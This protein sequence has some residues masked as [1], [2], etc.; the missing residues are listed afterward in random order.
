MIISFLIKYQKTIVLS[1]VAI[2]AYTVAVKASTI[3]TNLHYAALVLVENAQLA[4]NAALAVGRGFVVGFRVAVVALTRGVASARVA[5]QMLTKS[6]AA[7]PWGAL[8]VAVA[9]ATA[10]LVGFLSQTKRGEE[11][12]KRLASQLAKTNGEI[13]SER[14]EIDKLFHKLR[15]AEEGTSQYRKAKDEILSKY[16]QY[17][18]GLGQEVEALNDVAE[19]YRIITME[20]TNAARARGLAEA[21]KTADDTFNDTL[22]EQGRSLYSGLTGASRKVRVGNGSRTE[23]LSRNEVARWMHTLIA[24]ATQRQFTSG[25][26]DFLR[27][28]GV[29]MDRN[30]SWQG[31]DEVADALNKISEASFDRSEEVFT[32]SLIFGTP[33]NTYKDMTALQVER[34]MIELRETL[35]QN[36]S[37]SR[38]G[39]SAVLPN[40]NY[41]RFENN[42]DIQNELSQLEVLLERLQNADEG[43]VVV[44]SAP[45]DPNAPQGFTLP[46]SDKDRRKR[47]LEE[48]RRQIKERQD[49]KAALNAEKGLWEQEDT[50][51]TANYAAG[52]IS[53]REYLEQRQAILM[54]YFEAREDVY[55][56]FGLASEGEEDEDFL[57]LQKRKTEALLAWQRRQSQLSIDEIKREQQAVEAEAQLDFVTP[58][59]RLYRNEEALQQRLF[60]IRADYLDRILQ[61]Q[62]LTA[63]ERMRYE[64]QL[65]DLEGKEML[66]R[67]QVLAKRVQE[68]T[69]RYEYLSAQERYDREVEMLDAALEQNLINYKQYFEILKDLQKKYKDEILPDMAKPKSGKKAKA[70]AD[71]KEHDEALTRVEQLYQKGELSKEEYEAAKDRIEDEYF[72]RSE[73]RA[74][75]VGSTYTNQL[76][77]VYDAFKS[78]FDKSGEDGEHWA[79]KLG[80]LV[81]AVSGIMIGMMEQVTEYQRVCSEIELARV[82]KKYDREIELAEGNSYRV[83]QAE[84]AKERETARIKRESQRKMFAVQVASAVAQTAT[85]ALQAFGSA[86]WLPY[87]AS[88]I[89]GALAAAM[90]TAAGVVQIAT[91]KK[92]QQ[93]A[94]VQGYS[95]GGFTP[96]GK[97]DEAVGVVHAGEWVASQRLVNSPQARPLIEALDYAQRTNTIGSLR[98]ADVS[99]SITAPIALA[100][101]GQTAP[102]QQIVVQSAPAVVM[103]DAEL[104]KVISRLDSRLNEPFVTVATVSGDVGINRAQDEYSKLMRNKTPKSRRK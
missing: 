26:K 57:E 1:T 23:A 95:Q 22:D 38:Q 11:A 18:R 2:V 61:L 27:S 13:E 84:K 80:K 104:T 51:N 9:A 50:I 40:G 41:V 101:V 71:T 19:A 70:E 54:R 39:S 52:V 56:Q 63:D 102:T 30:G 44:A 12:Q 96:K 103:Q 74:R 66:R 15:S 46:E 34:F 42:V 90:A 16:G 93:L 8:A 88:L 32:N 4:W 75:E 68:W 21:N 67:R 20:A 69:K 45:A 77:D 55:K 28:I 33:A 5:F 59:S 62:T 99:R 83:R 6:M 82:E 7:N 47:E 81:G 25:T 58:S 94:E 76:L 24:E 64:Q 97:V 65:D 48:R 35:Q 49:F 53:Y 29:Y 100:E 3:A 85:N 98:M 43:V 17:L 92:Q 37:N 10:A 31:L 73:A 89:V 14:D 72:K 91:I 86:Q 36:Y 60:D 79:T 78:F 87:P